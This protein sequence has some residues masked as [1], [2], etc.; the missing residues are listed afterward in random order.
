MIPFGLRTRVIRLYKVIA[1][2]RN[3]DCGS[4][5]I[6]CKIR[7]KQGF[8]RSPTI[9]SIYI[10]KIDEF[11]EDAS[12][13]GTKIVVLAITLLYVVDIVLLARISFNLDKQL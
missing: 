8:H 7:V 9:F 12:C 11:L 10:D 4:K 13:A 3:N 5:E 6:N 1:K 2:I